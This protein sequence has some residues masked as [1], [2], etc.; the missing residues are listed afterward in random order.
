MG[1]GLSLNDPCAGSAVFLVN[2][3]DR[4]NP[5]SIFGAEENGG[6]ISIVD[7]DPGGVTVGNDVIPTPGGSDINNSIPSTPLV[8]TPDTAF[9]IPWRGAMVYVNDLE[10][11]ITKIN[12]TNS[13]ENGADLFDQTTLFKLNASTDNARY[14]YFSMDAGI[15]YSL[16][17]IHI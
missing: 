7:T 15:G 4:E 2:L 6:P 3:E 5:G 13:D 10:G 16:S 11:K 9:G 17:L 14:S 12:L 1:G 8:I